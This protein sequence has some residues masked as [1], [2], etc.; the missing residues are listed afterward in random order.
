MTQPRPSSRLRTIARLLVVILGLNLLVAV[1]KLVFGHWCGSLALSADGIHSL[2][3]ASAN[4][5]GLV[6]MSVAGRPPDANHPYG[7]RKY[8]TF[9]ALGV[10][11]T[12]L[13]GCRE[14]LA[15][16]LARLRTPAEP[17]ITPLA[18]GVML[19]TIAINLS[20][21][22][23]ERRAGRRLGSEL[24]VADA[25]HTQ[26]DLF[27]SLLVLASFVAHRFGI[28]WADLAA[29]ALIVAL[30]LKAG[31]S[32]LL[33]TLSTLADERRLPPETIESC[34]VQER[35]VLE[36]HNVRSRGP[37]DDIHV[38]L[39]VLVDPET[40]LAEAHRVGH[41]VERRLLA[42]FPG[43]TDVVVHVEPGL[44]TERATRR[45]GG[46]LKARG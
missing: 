36:A 10:V 41:R 42:N 7:H 25:A 33:S 37:L 44:A 2:L 12:M 3:D 32:I 5:I 8:E 26:S 28:A 13:L 17:S 45:E 23:V 16:G 35:G 27:A 43:V 15:E 22:T 38:D 39:H 30:I 14:I 40:P 6:G 11:C 21:A 31:V 46:G 20:V 29:T 34:A 18:V 24:L 19:V 9:A 1:A 4:V